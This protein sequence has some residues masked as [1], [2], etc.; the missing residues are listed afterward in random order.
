MSEN[1]LENIEHTLETTLENVRQVSES[2]YLKNTLEERSYYLL[3]RNISL[4]L[5]AERPSDTERQNSE[6]HRRSSENYPQ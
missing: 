6:A 1:T 2:I 5:S 4:R 3:G